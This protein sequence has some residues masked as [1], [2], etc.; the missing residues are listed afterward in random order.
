MKEENGL[1]P[2][3]KWLSM[4]KPSHDL[5]KS[6]WNHVSVARR[7]DT[8]SARGRPLHSCLQQRTTGIWKR[9][10]YKIKKGTKTQSHHARTKNK[11]R[12]TRKHRC[13]SN[14]TCGACMLKSTTYVW[15]AWKTQINGKVRRIH[16]LEEECRKD[17]TFSPIWST[18]SLWYRSNNLYEHLTSTLPKGQGH[19]DKRR[20]RNISDWR[21]LDVAAK[22]NVI[23][24]EKG[25]QRRN[26]W[27]LN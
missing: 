16:G 7:Q 6:S 10:Q 18:N 9:K 12:K 20:G 24:A 27:N 5:W 19:E 8:R 11:K 21:G 22:H 17:I 15:K 14:K 1:Y 4:D 25:H 2:Q 3:V 23:P 13:A 26:R